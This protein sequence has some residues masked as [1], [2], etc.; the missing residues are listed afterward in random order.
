MKKIMSVL[1]LLALLLSLTACTG[2][3]KGSS[4]AQTGEG[5]V[6]PEL[7]QYDLYAGFG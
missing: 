2:S 4:Q 5:A 6:L 3:D 1:L 7:G